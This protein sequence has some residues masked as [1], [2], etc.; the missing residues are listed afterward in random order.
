MDG[1]F[2]DILTEDVCSEDSLILSTEKDIFYNRLGHSQPYY[3]VGEI[4]RSRCSVDRQ[5]LSSWN[6]E[7]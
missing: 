5:Y 3:L 2:Q 7:S 1:M 4:Q 6:Q